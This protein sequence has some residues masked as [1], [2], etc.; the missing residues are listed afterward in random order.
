MNKTVR[1]RRHALGL[2]RKP[3]ALQGSSKKMNERLSKDG[4]DHDELWLLNETQLL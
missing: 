1:H 2:I 4:R 3:V